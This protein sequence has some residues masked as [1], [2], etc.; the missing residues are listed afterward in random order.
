L[1]AI[2]EQETEG[3][4][5]EKSGLSEFQSPR[6]ADRIRRAGAALA[7]ALALGLGIG[8]TVGVDVGPAG[9]SAQSSIASQTDVSAV[10]ERANAAVVTV[11]TLQEMSAASGNGLFP[12]LPNQQ[13]ELPSG[14]GA[15]VP[16]G[17]G[18]GFII[19]EEGHVITNNHVVAG[20]AG[21]EV[22]FADGTTATATLVGADA[23]QDIAVLKLDL[24][25]G[26]AVPATVTFGD[27]DLVQP[28][29]AV[30]A[31]GTPY[32][33]FENTVTAG[34]VNAVDRG[35]DSGVGYSLPNLIQH[36]ADIYPGNSGGPLLNAE[37]EVIGINVAKAF[38]Q[39]MGMVTGDGFNFAIESNAAEQVVGEIIAD[40]TYDR[41]YLGVRGQP[42][43]EGIEIV[44][45]ET[46]GPAAQAGLQP[47]DII[48][49]V[50][51]VAGDDPNEALDTILFDRHPGDV[52]TLEILRGG[53]PLTIDVTLGERPV[54]ITS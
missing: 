14:D 10:A 49:G 5:M 30:V 36:D 31:I 4:A 3:I 45:V 34:I 38:N 32:G 1:V 43:F 15:L 51:G 9:V 25:D 6:W 12:G 28:G 21:Y 41:S 37:G 17:S 46:N 18:S 13:G 16:V 50:A 26:Q 19:D 35:L 24:A 39:Q 42:A 48:T 33:E 20:G 23:F 27:S 8:A 52:V 53:Q 11:T 29:D 22:T 54:E 47:M 2:R 44:S 7:L 40:G